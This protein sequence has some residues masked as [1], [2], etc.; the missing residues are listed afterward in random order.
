M[1]RRRICIVT[2]TRAEYGLLHWLIKEVQAE[3]E[4]ELQLVVGG[5]HLSPQYG[6]T[7]AEIE[8]DGIPIAERVDMLVAGDTPEAAA[9]T[10]AKGLAGLGEALGRLK[11]HVVVL[12]GDRYEILAAALAA[13]LHRIPIAHIHGGE[14]TEGAVDDAIRHA[15]TKL[16]HLHFVAAEDYARR[17]IQMGEDP[18]RVF[19]VGAPALDNLRRTPLPGRAELEA[20]LGMALASPL[21]MVTYHPVTLRAGQAAA[22]A[23]LLAALDTVPQATVVVTGTNADVG[24][25]EVAALLADWAGRRQG[26]TLLVQSLGRV[27]YL[28]CVAIADAVVGNSSSGI[29]EAPALGVPT[30][31]IGSRQQGRVRA[32]SVIDCG[33]D[34]GAIA[35][36]IARALDPGFRAS[37]A[38]MAYPFGDG[39]AA[40]RMVEVLKT[41]PLDE[42]L[43]KPFRNLQG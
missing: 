34:R 28:G 11:P 25:D 17:V 3:P 20:G 32:Q 8:R 2:C 13:T 4:F 21:L 30:V 43:H 36:A 7:V 40:R 19:N 24:R 5:T 37:L 27:R 42:L 9:H 10:A 14:A 6:N 1:A 38:G 22:V 26:P 41:A 12:L 16:A 23:E 33:E 39:S 29:I 31:N 35:A 18:A 15:V